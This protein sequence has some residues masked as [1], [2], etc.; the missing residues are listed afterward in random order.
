MYSVESVL[1]DLIRNNHPYEKGWDFNNGD[2][3]F[4][5]F[6]DRLV[7]RGGR[8]LDLGIGFGRSSVFFALNGMEVVGVDRLPEPINLSIEQAAEAAKCLNKA[9]GVERVQERFFQVLEEEGLEIPTI[10]AIREWLK[11]F[12]VS[13]TEET[14][15]V[16]PSTS[17]LEDEIII[18]KIATK[19][20]TFI[21]KVPY[22]E[23]KP[24]LPEVPTSLQDQI[25]VSG[26]DTKATKPHEPLTQPVQMPAE[27]QE[28]PSE[29][30][31]DEAEQLLT[32]E[33]LNRLSPT[34]KK[35]IRSLPQSKNKAIKRKEWI[36]LSYKDELD[37]GGIDFQTARNRFY[38]NLKRV[39]SNLQKNNLEIAKTTDKEGNNSFYLTKSGEPKVT[40]ESKTDI[41]INEDE[42]IANYLRMIPRSSIEKEGELIPKFLDGEVYVLAL[43]LLNTNEGELEKLGIM[44]DQADKR[45]VESIL[46]SYRGLKSDKFVEKVKELLLPRL[47]LFYKKQPIVFLAQ[48]DDDAKSILTYYADIKEA[49]DLNQLFLEQPKND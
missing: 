34:L 9:R 38:A 36:S 35:I 8:V 37:Q 27:E 33:F 11:S 44:I 30:I 1:D 26:A 6:Q 23:S 2:P 31:K 47:K 28:Q 45:E 13:P 5:K 3:E 18:S 16:S 49:E 39:E 25:K 4:W 40:E 22:E 21:K 12:D 42:E 7:V 15:I 43:T 19:E 32:E 48:D 41:V 10:E 17:L 29:V 46:R 14:G 20:K 24:I